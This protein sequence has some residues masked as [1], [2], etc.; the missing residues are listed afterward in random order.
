M[1]VE[2]RSTLSPLA[3][4]GWYG[5]RTQESELRLTL[6]HLQS[7]DDQPNIFWSHFNSSTNE[8]TITL[9]KTL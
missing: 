3:Y 4:G 8:C 5:N 9:H 6:P 2:P 7:L 1:R